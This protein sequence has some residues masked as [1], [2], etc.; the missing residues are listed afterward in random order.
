[1]WGTLKREEQSGILNDQTLERLVIHIRAVFRR[2]K[3][4]P[5]RGA[6][7]GQP[8]GDAQDT[9]V[10]CILYYGTLVLVPRSHEPQPIVRSHPMSPDWT[11]P[12]SSI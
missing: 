1:M 7:S 9:R 5:F 11:Q 12:I 2:K 4:V 10:S 8:F 3:I 6:N